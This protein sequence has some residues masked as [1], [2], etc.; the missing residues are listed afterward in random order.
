M[1]QADASV[2]RK[3]RLKYPVIMEHK[4]L[5]TFKDDAY[6]YFCELSKIPRGSGNEK[7]ISNYLVSFAKENR[8][9]AVQDKSLNVLI[10]KNGSKGRENEAPLILQA[11]MDMVCEKNE[12]IAHDFLK[13]PI[14]PIIEGDWVKAQGTTLGADNGSGVALIM[15]VLA[16]DNLS[17]P[18]L[19]TIL[20]TAEETGCT[21]AAN[22]DVSLIKGKR[23]LNLDSGE[24]G[25]FCVACAGG[26]I[27]D[28]KVPVE[29]ENV[30]A[31]FIPYK[32]MVKGLVGGHSGSDID[33]GRLNANLLMAR[34]LEKLMQADIR[35]IDIKGGAKM[36]AIPR[37]CS[38][39]IAISENHLADLKL[40]V[41][42]TEAEFKA[43]AT[44]DRDLT[45]TLER[46]DIPGK[47]MNRATLRNV[48]N[49]ILHTPSG[50]QSMSNNIKGL[51]QTSN[52]PGVITCS[53]DTVVL[54]NFL[55]SSDY[56]DM[57]LVIEKIKTQAEKFG[58]K[59]YALEGFPI[60]EYKA[61][62]PLRDTMSAVFKEMYGK[63]PVS[64]AIHGGLECAIFAK[65]IPDGDFSSIGGPDIVDMHSPDER[66]SISS[67][68][69]T[70]DFLVMVLNKL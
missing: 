12:N 52:N 28:T 20:T 22:F 68:N 36:N 3:R 34:L 37:E 67:F 27:I 30:P 69:R 60:W 31:G 6:K 66:M 10:C 7:D 44:A 4:N 59:A 8:L 61:Y 35:L 53:E 21:G 64:A 57:N 42:Q 47:L 70:C 58:A 49:T 13:D 33:K 11:H 19:E 62:S 18:P 9:E 43:A 23:L 41:T 16:A 40:M 32:V 45:I 65:K 2:D 24:E 51:V 26:V 63:D 1:P 29:Y 25:I 5:K 50:V 54:T 38:A 56:A 17:H 55:R 15:A 48:I 14:I 39:W 46:S